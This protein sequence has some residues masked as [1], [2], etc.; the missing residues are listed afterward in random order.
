MKQCVPRDVLPDAERVLRAIEGDQRISAI[1]Q[2]ERLR[3]KHGAIPALATLEVIVHLD[4]DHE[5]QAGQALEALFACRP[6]NATAYALKAQFLATFEGESE[7]AIEA[8]QLA[9]DTPSQDSELLGQT[10]ALVG[11]MLADDGEGMAA[12]FHLLQAVRV[13]GQAPWVPRLAPMV[14]QAHYS[15]AYSA[16]EVGMDWVLTDSGAPWA[17]GYQ[18][19]LSE[20]DNDG[21]VVAALAKLD[22]LA[23]EHN[24]PAKLVTGLARLNGLLL[25]DDAAAALWGEV[26]A[27]DRAA[28]WLRIEAICWR[29]QSTRLGDEWYQPLL[30]LEFSAPQFDTVMEV[31]ASNRQLTA[32]PVSSSEGPPPRAAYLVLDREYQAD[33]SF[34]VEQTP[35]VLGLVL[36]YG[37]E[38]DRQ[39]RVIVSTRGSNAEALVGVLE[40]ASG[41]LLGK[42]SRRDEIARIPANL[43]PSISDFQFPE[44]K[45]AD[46]LFPMIAAVRHKLHEDVWSRTPHPL[47]DGLTPAMAA[48]DRSRRLAVEA[49]LLDH[50][51]R[52]KGQFDSP[53]LRQ[54]L[55][56]PPAPTEVAEPDRELSLLPLIYPPLGARPEP[57]AATSGASETPAGETTPESATPEESAKGEQ[58][59]EVGKPRP[60]LVNDELEPPLGL[61]DEQ[62][63]KALV[64]LIKRPT[65]PRAVQL[66]AAEA[67]RRGLQPAQV[68]FLAYLYSIADEDIDTPAQVRLINTGVELCENPELEIATLAHK[69]RLA[70]AF[71]L[72]EELSSSMLRLQSK[73]GSREDVRMLIQQVLIRAGVL[74]PGQPGEPMS[75]AP[76]FAGAGAA[77]SPEPSGIWTPGSAPPASK[78]KL[79]LPD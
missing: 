55:G 59:G 68:A 32:V 29:L 23:N 73:Y 1:E 14:V 56:L 22:R 17:E 60:D 20:L 34:D 27:D 42:E 74:R 71:R 61:T 43:P 30:E 64:L 62:L 38:T 41:G 2:L 4:L 31:F 44:T 75:V 6:P 63:S 47:L 77:A 21:R 18:Q 57:V 13:G 5:E 7:E 54:R 33:A 8:C 50:H 24:R 37:R 45:S 10:L 53:R 51:F 11:R 78:S 39:P 16:I 79:I 26:A 36:L 49:A 46:E 48:R 65:T 28:D 58:A 76:E 25:R 67:T 40:R 15:N 69:L 3:T 52:T 72:P 9:L 70:L 66:H 12:R 19:I 35:Q